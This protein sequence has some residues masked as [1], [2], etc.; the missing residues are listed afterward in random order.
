MSQGVT[1]VIFN[2]DSPG[3]CGRSLSG[4]IVCVIR[5][6]VEKQN[7]TK[8]DPGRFGVFLFAFW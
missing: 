1:F 4:G 7:A 2:L 8:K 3:D 6:L 5:W